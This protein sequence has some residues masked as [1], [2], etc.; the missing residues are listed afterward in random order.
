MELFI[1]TTQGGTQ[2]CLVN[3][4][5]KQV[6]FAPKLISGKGWTVV[7]VIGSKKTGRAEEKITDFDIYTLAQ[8]ELYAQNATRDAYNHD[9]AGIISA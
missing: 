8:A 5:G 1:K 2:H 9:V 6:R 4:G 3:A 7:R